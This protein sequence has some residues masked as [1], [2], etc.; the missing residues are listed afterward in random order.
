MVF[1]KQARKNWIENEILGSS[2]DWPQCSNSLNSWIAVCTYTCIWKYLSMSKQI[3]KTLHSTKIYIWR[4]LHLSD[5][6]KKNWHNT[7]TFTWQSLIKWKK[8]ISLFI[9][10]TFKSFNTFCTWLLCSQ[11]TLSYKQGIKLLAFWIWSINIV[12]ENYPFFFFVVQTKYL[13]S[14]KFSTSSL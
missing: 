13:K 5:Y 10:Y 12:L 9:N 3:K 14:I 7:K 6:L 8:K 11:C 2:T 1:C 4:D